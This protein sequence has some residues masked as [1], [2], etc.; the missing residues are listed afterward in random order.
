MNKSNKTLWQIVDSRAPGGI[1]SH[2]LELSCGLKQS[3]W[4]VEIV[5]IADHG[6][7]PL[8]QQLDQ[9]KIPYVCLNGSIT[10]LWAHMTQH[11]PDLIHTHGYKAG[12]LARLCGLFKRIPIVSTYHAGETGS[13]KL[14]LYNYLDKL[15]APL[16]VP[17]TVSEKI[18]SS[19]PVRSFKINNFVKIPSRTPRRSTGDIAFVGR[20]S[21]EK[22]PDLF[23]DIA[24]QFPTLKFHIYGDGPMRDTLSNHASPNVI[25]HGMVDMQKHW[26]NIDLLIMP[27]R[28]EGLPMAALEAMARS[29]PVVASAAG[30]LPSLITHNQNG[31]II[32]L[33]NTSCAVEI[34]N[35]W[36]GLSSHRQKNI[37]DKARSKIAHLY[38]P[39]AVI[40]Q[41]EQIYQGA[42]RGQKT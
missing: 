2:I 15:S 38:S 18:A 23:C 22:G 11:R 7:H 28:F 19:L 14:A 34:I 9:N 12:L 4:N 42:L 26:D 41:I 1:E 8:K 5:F 39:Q 27:S 16:S 10:G 17:I 13:G 24:R 25:F 30:D 29:I 3:G 37:R 35:Q 40:P 21:P 20:L 33:E 32:P 31:W 6:P 36:S